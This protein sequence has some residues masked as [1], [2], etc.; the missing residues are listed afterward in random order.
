[1]S[2][3]SQMAARLEDNLR[4]PNYCDR[5]D[6]AAALLR[7]AETLLQ[8][9]RSSINANGEL[10]ALCMQDIDALL[11]EA[12]A[13]TPTDLDEFEEWL[14]A[15]YPDLPSNAI[16]VRAAY[17]AAAAKAAQRIAELEGEVT[18]YKAEAEAV[19]R[20]C[21]YWMRGSI[22]TGEKVVAFERIR[23]FLGEPKA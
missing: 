1:M 22:M 9:I 23:A 5:C 18:R 10:S 20:E 3:L 16:A 12:E 15:N 21:E 6:E 11:G 17:H 7:E 13:M 4:T 19:L 8:R 2:K 14:K